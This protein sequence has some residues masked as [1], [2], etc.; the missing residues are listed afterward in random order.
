VA[1]EEGYRQAEAELDQKLK[2]AVK[3]KEALVGWKE[4]SLPP[5]RLSKDRK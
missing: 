2:D 4:K 5:E 3:K 1:Y